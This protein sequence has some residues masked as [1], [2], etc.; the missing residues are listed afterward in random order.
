MRI[1]TTKTILDILPNDKQHA[2]TAGRICSELNYRNDIEVR[3]IVNALRCAGYPV[4]ANSHGYWLSDNPAE[5]LETIH[6]LEHRMEGIA[7]AT[8]GLYHWLIEEGFVDGDS[9]NK[10]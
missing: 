3:E 7:K 9:K 10:V 4:C 2:I 1:M 8:G 5:V 6:G